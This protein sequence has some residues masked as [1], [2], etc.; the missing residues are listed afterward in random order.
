MKLFSVDFST[1]ITLLVN[2]YNKRKFSETNA[3]LAIGYLSQSVADL[4]KVQSCK[5]YDA[6]C[7]Q[8]PVL[9]KEMSE[10]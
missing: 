10:H 7:P 9:G 8:L 1:D 4:C 6:F 2:V 3:S 5:S